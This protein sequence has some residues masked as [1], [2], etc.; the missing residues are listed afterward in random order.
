MRSIRASSSLVLVSLSAAILF[1]PRPQYAAGA[2][3]G[4]APRLSRFA[5]RPD[6]TEAF[7]PAPNRRILL[8]ISLPDG[9]ILDSATLPAP[10]TGVELSPDGLRLAVTTPDGVVPMSVS[11]LAPDAAPIPTAE[12]PRLPEFTPNGSGL[13]VLCPQEHEMDEI[14]WTQGL[15]SAVIPLEDLPFGIA[16]STTCGC[17]AV[18][19]PRLGLVRILREA[20]HHAAEGI[21]IGPGP[22]WIA[23][24]GG[25]GS[26]PYGPEHGH[27]GLYPDLFPSREYLA[28][29]S[30]KADALFL[31]DVSSLAVV[32]T[33]DLE[34]P[35]AVE[36]SSS[37]AFVLTDGGKRAV[38]VSVDGAS[39]WFGQVLQTIRFDRDPAE[40]LRVAKGSGVC[41]ALG[42]NRRHLYSIDVSTLPLDGSERSA[43]GIALGRAPRR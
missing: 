17:A 42:H 23:A 9:G 36:A 28:V 40:T 24:A 12:G 27:G 13:C 39:P 31:I 7:L 20:G 30:R 35:C 33:L 38:I 18:T 6:G 32:Q 14:D 29:T 15:R 37:V 8:R 19:F 26:S 11:P 21:L 2:D 16:H 4:R 3:P 10:I 1:A 22:R 43:T 5:V 34:K 25:S 41:Y